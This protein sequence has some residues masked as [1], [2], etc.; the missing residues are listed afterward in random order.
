MRNR[1]APVVCWFGILGLLLAGVTQLGDARQTSTGVISAPQKAIEYVEW[2]RSD[3]PVWLAYNSDDA[4]LDAVRQNLAKPVKIRC[5]KK[6]LRDALKLVEA[7]IE[8]KILIN[9]V[10]LGV[11]GV[12]PATPITVEASGKLKDVFKKMLSVVEN[13]DAALS[14]RILPHG[15]LVTTGEDVNAEP[16]LRTF[17]LTYFLPDASHSDALV[18]L[19]VQ[20]VD[21]DSWVVVGGTSTI[22]HFGSQL[23]VSAPNSTIERIEE[24]LAKIAKQDRDHLKAPK[25][26][27]DK[28]VARGAP[29][30]LTAQDKKP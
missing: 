6:P 28:P 16:L 30:A 1:V 17:D 3:P 23:I 21:P 5:D 29:G 25:F 18:M 24:L 27:E 9:E 22:S 20:H 14:Y 2:K 8:T 26:K 12:D 19:I 11:V 10:E 15:F 7:Q 4:E 13:G